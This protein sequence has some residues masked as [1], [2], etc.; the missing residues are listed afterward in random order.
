MDDGNYYK[1][2]VDTKAVYVKYWLDN[3]V[4]AA[5]GWQRIQSIDRQL[6][7]LELAEL[8]R[9]ERLDT[10]QSGNDFSNVPIL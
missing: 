4:L 8:E 9:K 2:L 1:L 3:P 5:K 10:P 7:K 6:E